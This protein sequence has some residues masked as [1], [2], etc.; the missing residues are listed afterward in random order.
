MDSYN[1]IFEFAD[2]TDSAHAAGLLDQ[3]ATRPSPAPTLAVP[4]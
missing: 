2:N 4:S 3:F 1:A